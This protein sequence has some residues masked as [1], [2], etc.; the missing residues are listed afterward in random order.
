V[1]AA[2]AERLSQRLSGAAPADLAALRLRIH[3]PPDLPADEL[4][5]RIADA[6]AEALP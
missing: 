4:A 5:L 2:V 6:V 3:L 1:A